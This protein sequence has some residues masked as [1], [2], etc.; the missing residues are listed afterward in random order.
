MLRHMSHYYV[1]PQVYAAETHNAFQQRRVL[2]CGVA[3]DLY[4][5]SIQDTY[6]ARSITIG[7]CQPQILLYVCP[8]Y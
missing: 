5:I 3:Y 7:S 2:M 6:S 4:Y 8:W 1:T